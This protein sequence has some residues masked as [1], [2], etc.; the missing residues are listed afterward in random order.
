LVG[1]KKFGADKRQKKPKSLGMGGFLVHPQNGFN[2]LMLNWCIGDC[3]FT[4]AN[5]VMF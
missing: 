2:G 4:P 1:G 5:F 3:W